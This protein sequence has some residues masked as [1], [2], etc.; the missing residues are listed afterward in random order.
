MTPIRPLAGSI[1]DLGR[2]VEHLLAEP[3]EETPDA[4]DLRLMMLNASQDRLAHALGQMRAV[5]DGYAVLLPPAN[6]GAEP[7]LPAGKSAGWISESQH[8]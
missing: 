4:R 5:L 1:A 2:R 6:S 7:T 8:G 3:A